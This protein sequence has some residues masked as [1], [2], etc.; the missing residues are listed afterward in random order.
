MS[1]ILVAGSS[2]LVGSDLVP[3]L[4]GAGNDV[5]RLVRKKS[6][7]LHEILWDPSAGKINSD[8]IEGFDAVV[9]LSGDSIATGR[10]S[11][12]KKLNILKSR[13]ETTAL[14]AKT[15]AGLKR[16]PQ[17][18]V[19]ASAVGIYGDT[20]SV[21]VT[22][23][24][25]DGTGFLADVCEAWEE[26]MLPA[27]KAGVRIVKVRIG[28]VLSGKGG[29][30]SAMLLPFKL[31]LG[32]V[33]GSGEQFMSWIALIDLVRVINEVIVNQA[34]EGAVNAVSPQ[35]VTNREFTK[36]L[37]KVLGRPTVLPMPAFAARL[38]FGEMADALLLSSARVQPIR[39]EGAGYCFRFGELELAL[40]QGL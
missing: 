9:N 6:G 11:E 35:N 32:G 10:W 30:L 23:I 1:K 7:S 25:P 8:E 31:G 27:E 37:G 2:G 12:Q 22:E 34:Y 18:W 20:G 5:Y 28:M 16:K 13:V 40:R 26:A 4:I 3:F 39:L 33:I 19:N 14:L 36:T 17:V 15:I 38:A 24:A 21:A 29:A